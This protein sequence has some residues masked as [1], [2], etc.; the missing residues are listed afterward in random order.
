MRYTIGATM[1]DKKT[2]E[3]NDG[4]YAVSKLGTA[5]LL[6]EFNIEKYKD[7]FGLY[8]F[9]NIEDAVKY[10]RCLSRCYRRDDVWGNKQIKSKKIRRFY[11]LKVDSSR[12]N[13]DL[14][15]D[16][17]TTHKNKYDEFGHKLEKEETLYIYN[18]VH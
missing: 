13:V 7:S 18:I 1:I 6:N 8:I 4:Y 15:F 9:D 17:P 5:I 14:D 2:N 3:I 12:F 10:S 11:P 16:N